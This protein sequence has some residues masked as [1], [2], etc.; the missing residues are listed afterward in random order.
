MHCARSTSDGRRSGSPST[1][2]ALWL[3]GALLG[4]L[5]SAGVACKEA[6]DAAPKGAVEEM[7]QAT[8]S[9]DAVRAFELL[10]PA[11]RARLERMAR[12]ATAQLG[13]TRKVAPHEL[14]AVS[15][16]PT[17]FELAEI[18]LLEQ[19]AERARV[20]LKAR[21]ERGEEVLEL[22]RVGGRWRILLPDASGRSQ[23]DRPI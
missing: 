23:A 10:A 17:R 4:L 14:L 19:T 8:L 16:H 13:G 9:G 18:V 6:R 15:L 2:C 7:M 11:T 1:R 12:V 3:A 5:G 20:K 21:G 22:V